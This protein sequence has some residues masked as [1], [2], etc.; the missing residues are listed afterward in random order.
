MHPASPPRLRWPLGPFL[1]SQTHTHTTRIRHQPRRTGRLTLSCFPAVALTPS[2]EG[3]NGLVAGEPAVVERYIAA[4]EAQPQFA[5]I[6]SVIV[7][8][9]HS[10]AAEEPRPT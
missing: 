1:W 2:Q 9:H 8:P 6:Q 5:S 4:M 10:P 3:I 7:A